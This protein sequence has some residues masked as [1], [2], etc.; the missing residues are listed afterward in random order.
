MS[1]YQADYYKNPTPYTS[2]DKREPVP[3]WGVDPRIA[4]PRRVGVGAW[5]AQTDTGRRAIMRPDAVRRP[6]S[7]SD[8]L[9][10]ALETQKGGDLTPQNGGAPPAPNGEVQLPPPAAEESLLDKVPIWV[11]PLGAAVIVG[12]LYWYTS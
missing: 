9:A 11:F 12:G 2:S 3:G 5:A 1:Y 10:K 7:R 8:L 6:I 4:G